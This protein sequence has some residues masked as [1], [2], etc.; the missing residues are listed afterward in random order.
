[1]L[2]TSLKIVIRNLRKY[3]TT[4]WINI[5]GLAVGLAVVMLA[6]LYVHFQISFDSFHTNL[7]RISGVKLGDLFATPPA[8]GEYVKENIPEVATSVRFEDWNGRKV[9]LTYNNKSVI[10]RKIIYTDPSVFDVFSFKVIAG[11]PQTALINPNSLVLSQSEA[12]NLFGEADP[13]GKMVKYEGHEDFIVTAIVEDPPANASHVYGGF[14]S[15]S[16]PEE[17]ATTWDGWYYQTYLF[18]EKNA[19]SSVVEQKVNSLITQFFEE[20]NADVD[21][22]NYAVSFLPLKDLYFA[23]VATDH[24]RYGNRQSVYLFLAVGLFI[25][26]LAILNYINLTTAHSSTRLKEIAIRKAVG[27][28]RQQLAGQFLAE[29]VVISL[30]ATGCGVL[31]AYLFLPYVNRLASTGM[32]FSLMENPLLIVLILGGAILVGLLAGL[33]PA[34]YLTSIGTIRGLKGLDNNRESGLK[35][36][37]G[38]TLFQFVVSGILLIATVVIMQQRD[39]IRKKDLGFKPEQIVWFDLNEVLEENKETF[40]T[41]LLQNPGIQE[42]SFTR[43]NEADADNYWSDRIDGEEIRIHPF[44]VDAHYIDLMGL[45]LIQG[46]NFSDAHVSDPNKSII[47]NK[48]AIRQYGLDSPIG[49]EVFGR[50]IIGVVEDFNYQSLH[51]KIA[52]L[53]LIFMNGV[54]KANVKI[55]SNDL[56]ATLGFIKTQW[57]KFTPEYPFEYHF[58]EEN[59]GQL[60]ASENKAVVLFNYFSFTALFIACLGLYGLAAFSATSRTKEIGI[61]KVVGASVLEIVFMLSKDF[62]RWVFLANLIAWPIAWYAMHLWLR[63]YAYHIELTFWPFLLSGIAALATALLTV[64]WQAIRAATANPVE[65]L[66]YE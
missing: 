63:N 19:E 45:N 54:N 14:A 49:K 29:S 43:F 8:L 30:I 56:A 20:H 62:T 12:F 51:Q 2:R 15:F 60:Y 3:K 27:S 53:G 34:W 22:K 23:S 18:I 16:N 58:L 11:D 61:R 37:R 48:A 13:L 35:L 6:F 28:Q 7:D 42:V 44:W 36:R 50:T 40:R 46:R 66:R 5:L 26:V 17:L 38:L 57:Q 33:I 41:M 52:P 47:L 10:V 1:M 64:S 21:P 24:H 9:L 25:L 39:F 4:S 65:S 55:S 59:Y 31:L 32:E